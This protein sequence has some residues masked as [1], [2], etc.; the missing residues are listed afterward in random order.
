MYIC[1]AQKKGQINNVVTQGEQSWDHWDWF[2]WVAL[3]VF[4]SHIIPPS[5]PPLPLVVSRWLVTGP[6]RHSFIFLQQVKLQLQQTL[7]AKKAAAWNILLL[8]SQKYWCDPVRSQ[9]GFRVC[10]KEKGWNLTPFYVDQCLR[11]V[12]EW[13]ICI[14][15]SQIQR[16]K[17]KNSMLTKRWKVILSWVGR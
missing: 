13:V 4:D 10:L 14:L 12:N 8:T 7:F 1:V 6:Y 3:G 2:F 9:A 16:T 15:L 5:P 17:F 11:Y